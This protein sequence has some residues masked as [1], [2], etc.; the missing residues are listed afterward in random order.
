M[1]IRPI[2]FFVLVVLMVFGFLGAPL[3]ANV[4]G[5]MQTFAPNTDGLDF[6]TVHSSRPLKKGF[7][8]VGGHFS[9]AKDHLQVFNPLGTQ[10]HLNY[11][12]QLVEFDTDVSY[13]LGKQLGVF[14]AVPTLLWQ[15]SAKDQSVDVRL[16]LDL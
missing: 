2:R 1:S 3:W 16:V 6:I 12:D 5:D 10:E 15:E 4:L 14:L 11:S 7:F 9:Y 8:A 13:A